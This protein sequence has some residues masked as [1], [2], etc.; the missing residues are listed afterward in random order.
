VKSANRVIFNTVVLNARLVIGMAIGLFTIRLVLSALGETDYGIYTLVAGLI[1]M[2]GILNSS[3]TMA[4]MRFMAYSLGTG[5]EETIR[6]TFNTTLFL[7]FIIGLIVIAIM[8]VGGFFMFEYLLN[9]PREKMFSAKIVFHFM[10]ITSFITIISV[11]YDAVINSHENILVL[12][13]VDLLGNVL[14]LGT[15]IYLTYSKTNLLILYGFLILLTQIILR[16]IK[17]WYSVLKYKECKIN[18]RIYIDKELSKTILSFSGWNLLANIGAI[19]VIQVKSIFLNMFHGVT[20][21]ASD[22]IASTLSGQVNMI[23]VSMTRAI[24]P[25]LVKS[26]GSGNRQKMISLTEIA[27]KFSIILFSIFAIPA[28]L[29]THYLLN[30]WLKT[31]PEYAIIFCQI[32]MI[33]LLIEKFTFEITTAI[34]TVGK[35]RNY[36]II[37]TIILLLNIP[38]YYVVLSIGFP[39]YSIYLASIVVSLAGAFNRL[40]FG[41]KIAEINIKR[42]FKNGISPVLVP[43]FLAT[44]FALAVH[45][46]FPESIFRLF[47]TTFTCIVTGTTIF[48][49]FGLKKEETKILKQIINTMFLKSGLIK[50]RPIN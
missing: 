31:V 23:S 13:L 18:F 37:E 4:S 11:P 6:K 22:G 29:E 20:V 17:Q 7:H 16:I 46:Y 14:S 21:N 42:F 48:W 36:Q 26:E 49:L 28:I 47:I 35:I 41:K 12:S 25:Q 5:K 24:N 8:E 44:I 40:Y 32:I 1:G 27:T 33:G 2:L 9:I 15:A 39:P 38:I 10:V 34:R 45:L 43:I 30:L 3:M 19:S 50:S